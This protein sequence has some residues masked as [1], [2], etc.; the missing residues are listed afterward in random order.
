ML[1]KGL[2]ARAIAYKLGYTHVSGVINW[3]NTNAPALRERMRVAFAPTAGKPVEREE[4][5]RRLKMLIPFQDAEM[6]PVQV[7][8]WA[9]RNFPDGDFRLALEDYAGDELEV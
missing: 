8:A 1:D 4:A 3:C 9:L 7:A 6:N 5:V 2:R